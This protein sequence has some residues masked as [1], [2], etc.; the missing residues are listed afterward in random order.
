MAKC[1]GLYF[2]NAE[3]MLWAP[4]PDIEMDMSPVGWG[5]SGTFLNG[6]AYVRRSQNAAQA[7]RM[8]W[9][10][11]KDEDLAKVFDFYH[12]RYGS[13]P[14]YMLMPGTYDNVLPRAWSMPRL[15]IEDAPS[16]ARGEPRPV[17]EVVGETEGRP[18]VAAKYE[19]TDPDSPRRALTI[20]L[21]PGHYLHIGVNGQFDAGMGLY[22]GDTRVPTLSLGSS[23]ITS[24]TISEPGLHTLSL[25]GTGEAVISAMTARITTSPDRHSGEFVPGKGTSA[26]EFEPGSVGKTMYSAAKNWYHGS[27]TLVEVGQWL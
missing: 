24:L 6:G 18:A 21:P 27:A 3:K 7:Y 25:R 23:V 5:E 17:P 10:M 15:Q 9:T 8:T 16:F 4:A 14:F 12:G 13:G 11:F 20:P 2:G 22:A 1:K 19:F 26:V